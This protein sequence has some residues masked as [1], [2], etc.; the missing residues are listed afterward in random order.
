MQ[1]VVLC[2]KNTCRANDSQT[3]HETGEKY[4][5]CNL[6]KLVQMIFMNYISIIYMIKQM[7]WS[8]ASRSV[9]LNSSALSNM[10]RFFILAC[11][12]F[13]AKVLCPV[14]LGFFRKCS[15]ANVFSCTHDTLLSLC[16]CSNTQRN[17]L[18]SGSKDPNL[19]LL[20][21]HVTN[22]STGG[23]VIFIYIVL[24][25]I[26]I[27]TKQLRVGLSINNRSCLAQRDEMH[28]FLLT[29]QCCQNV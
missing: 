27:E 5:E 16:V 15:P 2:N 11:G 1:Q 28:W 21:E 17:P 12:L 20:V 3:S 19:C 23:Q 10:Y 25:T 7:D 26:Q 18:N 13:S 4:I 24:L 9:Y 8:A 14:F 6:T 22:L 29:N